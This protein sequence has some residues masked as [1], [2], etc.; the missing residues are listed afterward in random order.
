M[1]RLIILASLLISLTSCWI[2][3]DTSNID[4]DNKSVETDLA[5]TQGKGN[6]EYIN[7]ND[8]IIYSDNNSETSF[9]EILISLGDKEVGFFTGLIDDK[10]IEIEIDERIIEYLYPREMTWIFK[11]LLNIG[12]KITFQYKTSPGG[13]K[14]LTEIE[15]IEGSKIIKGAIGIVTNSHRDNLEITVEGEAQ[16]FLIPNGYLEHEINLGDMVIF[17]Y[18]IDKNGNFLIRHITKR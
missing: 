10:L 6:R 7:D 16:E 13:Q 11:D 1:K 5:E 3:K 2:Q 12:D 15:T 8:N 18:Y 17:D 4:L 14:I 9:Q